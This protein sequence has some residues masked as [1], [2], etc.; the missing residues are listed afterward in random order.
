MQ[1]LGFQWTHFS[2]F[3]VRGTFIGM[4]RES[5]ISTEIETK[6]LGSLY[7]GPFMVIYGY[8]LSRINKMLEDFF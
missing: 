3:Y 4:S 5:L 8:T 1:H 2:D 6:M 7:E